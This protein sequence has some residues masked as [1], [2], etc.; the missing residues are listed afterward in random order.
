MPE[1]GHHENPDRHMQEHRGYDP[2]GHQGQPSESRNVSNPASEESQQRKGTAN[3]GFAAMDPERQRKIA[4]EGG[5]AAH[6]QGVAHEWS[7]EEARKAGR[8]GGQKVSQNREHMSNIGRKGGQSSGTRRG[9]SDEQN[10]RS[11]E[12]Q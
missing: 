3:R 11:E 7:R 10:L 4:S 1:R 9:S 2:V 6:K 12:Q 8:K 5:R